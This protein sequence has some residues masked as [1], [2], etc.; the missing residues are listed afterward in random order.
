M[1]PNLKAFEFTEKLIFT[2]VGTEPKSVV[3]NREAHLEEG[4]E[5]RFLVGKLASAQ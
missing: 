4:K 1:S 2:F 3:Y 5:V